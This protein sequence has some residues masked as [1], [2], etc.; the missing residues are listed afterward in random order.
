M[1]KLDFLRKLDKYLAV[2]EK[3]ERREILAFYEERFYTGT[4]YENKTEEEVIAELESPEVI[5]RNVLEEYGASTT[6]VKTKEERYSNISLFHVIF[7][8]SFDVIIASWLIPTLFAAAVSIIGSSFTYVGSIGMIIGERTTVDEFS[9]AFITGAYILLFLFGLAVFEAGLFVTKKIFIWHLN[10]FKFKNRDKMIKKLSHLSLD[11]WFK[12]HRAIK[13]VKSFV[14]VGALVLL[15]YSGFWIF[16]NFDQVQAEYGQG[17]VVNETFTE[18]FTAEIAE[19]SDWSI[20]SDFGS[21]DAEIVYITGNEF[22]VKHSYYDNDEFVYDFDFEDNILT[23]ENKQEI[24]FFWNVSQL[25]MLFGKNN[26]VRIEVPI[27]LALGDVNLE[28]S[29]GKVTILSGEFGNLDI[30]TSNGEVRLADLTTEDIKINVTNGGIYVRDIESLSTSIINLNSTNGA[31]VVDDV[32]F[33]TYDIN[34]TNGRVDLENLNVTLKDGVKINV[35]TT[36]GKIAMSNCYL[37]KIYLHTTNGDIDFINSD[38]SFH[39]ADFVKMTTNGD[40]ESNV[41]E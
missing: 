29:N 9:F 34:T 28:T 12:K 3:D 8:L 2:L 40:I 37:N 31:I 16:N 7:I 22:N 13:R 23:V 4:I 11:S 17:S 36:N 19:G 41:T 30:R 10:V 35:N 24:Q 32:N 39:P 38:T 26:E 25:F 33:A 15:I 27:S 18:D 21:M 5:A 14:G 20:V 6:Y 1:N